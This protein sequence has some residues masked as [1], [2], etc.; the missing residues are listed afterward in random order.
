M[1]VASSADFSVCRFKDKVMGSLLGPEF[2]FEYRQDDHRQ[3][4]IVILT[5]VRAREE[6][7]GKYSCQNGNDNTDRD[8]VMVYVTYYGKFE[9]V[10]L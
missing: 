8:A 5:K 1:T 10:I 2:G 6:D 7:S 3:R 4:Y 9:T